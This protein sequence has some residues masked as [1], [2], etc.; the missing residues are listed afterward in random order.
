MMRLLLLCLCVAALAGADPINTNI[1]TG[2]TPPVF[3]ETVPFTTVITVQNPYDKAV[4]ITE[5]DSTCTCARQDLGTRFLLPKATTTLDLEVD[6]ANRSGQERLGIT[7][8][9]SDPALEPIEVVALWEVRAHVQVD[10]LTG[11]TDTLTRPPRA[12]RDV[13]RYPSKVRPDE[14]HKLGKRIRISSPEGQVPEGGL[15][16][17]AI[18]CPSD[19]LRFT[20]TTQADGS[21]LLEMTGNPE[22]KDVKEGVSEITV[23]LRTNHPQKAEIPLVFTQY[24]GKDAGQVVFDPNAEKKP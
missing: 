14:L 6:N 12:F 23:T 5:I 10:S 18:D 9:L 24:I 3:A 19:L 11:Q 13:Y 2:M 20:Q 7:L 15:T 8:Y 17:T 22:A 1:A 21:I 4:R 16:I